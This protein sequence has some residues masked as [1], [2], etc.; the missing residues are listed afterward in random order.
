MEIFIDA[1]ID[2]LR[3]FPFLFAA[4]ICLEYMEHKTSARMV[5]F[6]SK[7]RAG[8]PLIGS[9]FGA[10][11]Q[12]GFS[13]AAANFYAARVISLGTL[14]A[15]F[16]STSDETLPILLA[17]AASGKLIAFIVFYKIICGVV[18]GYAVNFICFRHRKHPEINIEQLC[19][20]E[21][22][23]CNGGLL[24]P[25]LHHSLNITLFI[26]AVNLLLNLVMCF[27]APQ[28]IAE[29]MQMP[30]L[31]EVL[32]ALIGLIPNCS[33]SVILTQLYLE[34]YI[35]LNALM[36]GSLVSGGVGLLVLFRVNRHP[37]ENLGI[38]ALLYICGLIGGLCCGLLPNEWLYYGR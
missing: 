23:H 10:V 28:D 37:K 7:A 9:L 3:I 33:S 34:D 14:L 21:N 18:F 32:C 15:I 29:Y 6:I 5:G 12:C 20:N 27:F 25:A 4:Y 26:F 1:V 17:D 30:L 8:G 35:S 13:A 22:C 16:L 24:M 36:S 2:T 19:E 11:P 38:I 31:G